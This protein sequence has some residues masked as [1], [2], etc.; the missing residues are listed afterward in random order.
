MIVF[1]PFLQF[2]DPRRIPPLCRQ[3]ATSA[4]VD[5]PLAQRLKCSNV[6]HWMLVGDAM[7]VRQSRGDEFVA[8]KRQN[9]NVEQ[10]RER[11]RGD[12]HGDCALCGVS[13]A[14]GR[15]RITRPIASMLRWRLH[16][17]GRRRGGT[18]GWPLLCPAQ[19]LVGRI[20]T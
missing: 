1:K 9:P 10:T 4:V 20:Q 16:P 8:E 7:R 12:I 18:I 19:H 17:P 15:A 13:Q 3:A 11:M 6:S 14:L 2:Q 5:A